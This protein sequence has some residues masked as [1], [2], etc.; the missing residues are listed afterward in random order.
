MAK[1][2]LYTYAL[3]I[4]GNFEQGNKAHS[5]KIKRSIPE[6]YTWLLYI[7]VIIR[8][9]S[10]TVEKTKTKSENDDQQNFQWW[11]QFIQVT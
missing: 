4:D 2:Q 6:S 10:V 3:L 1:I 11:L 8:L 9:L 5:L 7:V